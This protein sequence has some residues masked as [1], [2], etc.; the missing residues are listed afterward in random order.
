MCKLFLLHS[1]VTL[2]RAAI[3][4]P[5][6][7]LVYFFLQAHRTSTRYIKVKTCAEED[8]RYREFSV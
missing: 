1:S 7:E 2:H 4:V 6:K 8:Y 5:F 3:S